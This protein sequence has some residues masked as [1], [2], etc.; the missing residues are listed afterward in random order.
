[1]DNIA[2]YADMKR[3]RTVD[4]YQ[5]RPTFSSYQHQNTMMEPGATQRLQGKRIYHHANHKPKQEAHHSPKR[6]HEEG[7]NV[8]QRLRRGKQPSTLML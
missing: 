4:G 1:M 5:P 7:P 2:Y 8:N 3:S 6:I